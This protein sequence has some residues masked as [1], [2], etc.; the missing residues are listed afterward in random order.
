MIQYLT[1][2]VDGIE[3]LITVN[4]IVLPSIVIVFL[5]YLRTNKEAVKYRKFS[6]VLAAR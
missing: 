2:M 6:R 4:F 1:S 3:L 5:C